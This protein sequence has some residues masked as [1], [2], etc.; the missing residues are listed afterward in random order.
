[1]IKGSHQMPSQPSAEEWKAVEENAYN[2]IGLRQV[3]HELRKDL[4][5]NK[6]CSR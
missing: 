3:K 5:H 6:I 4:A 2:G 1:M